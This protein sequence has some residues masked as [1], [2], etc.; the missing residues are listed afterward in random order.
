MEMNKPTLSPKLQKSMSCQRT[1]R[2]G[3]CSKFIRK[4]ERKQ[5]MPMPSNVYE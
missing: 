3:N 2:N 1:E 5:G 4:N